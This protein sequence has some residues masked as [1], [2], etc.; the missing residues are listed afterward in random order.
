MAV[1]TK[2]QINAGHWYTADGEPAHRIATADGA[3][4]RVTTI[5][6]A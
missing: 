4:E 2:N 6:D 5:R 3:G 1:L